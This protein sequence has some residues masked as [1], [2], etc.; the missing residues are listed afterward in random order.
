MFGKTYNV[1]VDESEIVVK[2][3]FWQGLAR[4]TMTSPPLSAALITMSAFVFFVFWLFSVLK[5]FTVANLR[6][7]IS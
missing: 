2:A 5:L 6:Y 7:K 4:Q 1:L 3:S